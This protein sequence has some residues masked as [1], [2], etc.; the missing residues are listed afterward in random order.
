MDLLDAL[1]GQFV[2]ETV[3]IE[4]LVFGDSPRSGGERPEHTALLTQCGVP[5]PPILVHRSSMR[6]IDGVHRV[7]AAQAQGAATIEAMMLDCSWE[8]A[9]VVAVAANRSVGLPLSL[10]DRRS[11]VTRI[12][13]SHP[14]W[15]DRSIASLTGLS[16]KTVCAIRNA[17]VERAEFTVLVSRTGRDGRA[18]PMDAAV[19][20]RAAA[21]YLEQHPDSS[22]RTV[23]RHA[24]VS[25]NTVR[26]VRMRLARGEDPVV[27]SAKR[28]CR[29]ARKT[30]VLR[31]R[32]PA[33][34]VDRPI[35]GTVRPL[36]ASLSRD[37]AVRMTDAGRE[38]VRWLYGH[39]VDE[40]D[41]N[42]LVAAIPG[43][44]RREVAAIADR[45]AMNWSAIARRIEGTTA[46]P[47]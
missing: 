30:A 35:S 17:S 11:A 14:Q 40:V 9:F 28:P 6:I 41:V 32:V 37:P 26:D 19:G 4:G 1:E 23:A 27:A 33:P 2:S 5:L 8:S 18:R 36:L 42:A 22:L 21:A 43:H 29:P 16:A 10:D 46:K 3:E 47:K 44:R 45:C 15:S 24:G 13:L 20:R 12:L 39:S 25:P 7:R 38:L 31:N 34:S